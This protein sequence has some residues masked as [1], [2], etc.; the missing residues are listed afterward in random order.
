MRKNSRR[1]RYLTAGLA[2]FTGLTVAAP[3][4][5]AAPPTTQPA[6][7]G[8][9]ARPQPDSDLAPGWKKSSDVL[10]T[11]VG[12]TTGFHLYSASE[13][14]AF[15]WKTLATLTAS[16]LDLGSW[17][18]QVCV[19]G[20]GRYAVAVY[21]P[22]TAANSPRL[23]A[24][25]AL[26]AV[27]DTRTGKATRLTEG[28]QLAYFNPACGPDDRVLLTRAVGDDGQK[29]DLLTVDAAAGRVTGTRRID[30]QF[31]TPAPAP[32]GD[33]GMAN[34]KLVRVGP[35][36]ELTAVAQP[37]GR[38]FAVR[39]TAHQGVDIASVDGDRAVV[40]RF[41]GGALRRVGS[42]PWN[43]LQLFG[44]TGGGN[45]VVGDTTAVN[46]GVAELAKLSSDRQVQAVS[47]HGHLLAEIL[48]TGQAARAGTSP[49]AHA[50]PRDA[51]TLT[52]TTR[53]THSG[54][55][56]TGAVTTTRAPTL[57]A[58]SAPKAP[59]ALTSDPTPTCAIARNDPAL[60]AFQVSPD[61]VEWA[62]DRAV[63]GTLTTNRP[64][65]YL[66]TGQAAYSPQ[67]MFPPHAVRGGGTVPAQVMLG[68]LAQETNLSQ[69]S[70][71]AVPGDTGNP[72]VA[73]YYGNGGDGVSIN[74]PAADCG[75]GIGQVTTGMRVGDTTYTRAQQIAIATDYAANI[76]A[77]LNIL[78]D[79]WNELY[80]EPAGRSYVNDG[81]A[82]Y[83]ENWF[84]AVWTYNSGYHPNSEAPANAGYWGV[85]YLNNP[86]N[87][88]YPSN[89]DPF[90]RNSYADAATPSHWSYPERIMGWAE[91]PQ[92]KGTPATN[93]YATPAFGSATTDMI[94]TAGKITVPTRA[95]FCDAGNHCNSTTA[96]PC[97]SWNGAC[98]WRGTATFAN[99]SANQCATERLSY[100][101][102]AAEPGVKRVYDRDCSTFNPLKDPYHQPGGN[103]AVVYDLNDT[104]QYALG[105]PNVPASQGK[106]TL[107]TGYPG[108]ANGAASALVDVHQ[109]G[110]GYNG[111]MW[112]THTYQPDD[113]L[114]P[115]RYN[116]THEV[117][118]TWT[119]YLGLGETQL[120]RYDIWVHIPSHGG[121]NTQS[122]YVVYADAY[123]RQVGIGPD[124]KHPVACQIN[125]HSST[126]VTQGFDRWVSIGN[127]ELGRGARVVLNN[128]EHDYA[129][130]NG[131]VDVAFDA[132]AFVPTVPS[133][134]QH[135]GDDYPN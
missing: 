93:A 8:Q 33:Y 127:Y 25:G 109:A 53:S 104:S 16:A 81:S 56:L 80:D 116:A 45:A 130:P 117:V 115:D 39:A 126:P 58:I 57:D 129:V 2:L 24:S 68:I 61:M 48:L 11:G 103:T 105:C 41:V 14:D 122:E 37:Q 86:A 17:T 35:A 26:A 78:I 111:H 13:K 134:G 15:A 29:T 73:D 4:A 1:L 113:V 135:C 6:P 77:G 19:T 83:V 88:A 23:M 92:L 40:Q 18:G 119:P 43:K 121:D 10:V 5:E 101:A 72:L 63:H 59:A 30:A 112:F 114:G 38:P 99:C 32:D 120:Q 79:K 107:R 36:G 7:A 12:D 98:W 123:D 128:I 20:S 65:N 89:R 64:A 131:T 51:G 67:G 94:H 22:A 106:F 82:G 87:P 54:R 96:D 69:A 52:V 90:L 133:P 97:P 85:G 62:V 60:Q 124:P 9:A 47:G 46:D 27:V 50:D 102:G 125:Q 70:W 28:V 21:A 42:G 74:Y 71:H 44:L 76:A 100:S 66:K 95:T 132:M 55:V 84:L 75:Y 118:G 110:A 3:G 34:G 49:L 108:G 91:T 31:T